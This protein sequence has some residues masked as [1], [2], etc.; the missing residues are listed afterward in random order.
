MR[1]TT[2]R[3]TDGTK[4]CWVKV[5]VGIVFQ[6]V[7]VDGESFISKNFDG[8]LDGSDPVIEWIRPCD[9]ALTSKD[10]DGQLPLLTGDLGRYV[11]NTVMANIEFCNR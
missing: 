2:T 6:I 7:Q 9:P 11:H 5:Q 10:R 1:A 8:S 4:S 3:P